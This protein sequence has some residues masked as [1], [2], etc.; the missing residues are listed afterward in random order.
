MENKPIDIEARSEEL[1]DY[2]TKYIKE[3]Y[4]YNEIKQFLM[5]GGMDEPTAKAVIAQV[6]ILQKKKAKEEMKHGI[7]I[8][9]GGIALVV[10]G[11]LLPFDE[12]NPRRHVIFYGPIIIGLGMFFRGLSKSK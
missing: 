6:L 11:Y 12:T 4:A 9:L 10:L 5:D 1:Y 2:V 7:Y 8:T 3:N